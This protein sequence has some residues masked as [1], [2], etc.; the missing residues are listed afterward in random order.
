MGGNLRTVVGVDEA[1]YGPL[2]GPLVVG[3]A[4]FRLTGEGGGTERRLAGVAGPRGALPVGDSKRIYRG[5]LGFSALERSVLAFARCAARC[6]VPDAPR[7]TP[8]WSPGFPPALPVEAGGEAVRAGQERLAEALRESGV[9]VRAVMTRTVGVAEFNHGVE[10]LGSKAALLFEAAMEV[11]A[12]WIEEDGEVEVR[13]D[14]HGGRRRY[15]PLLAARFP[16]TPFWVLG[17]SPGVSAYRLVRPG[18]EITVSFETR[19]D[20]RYFEVGLASMAAKYVRE[21]H[22]RAFNAYFSGADPS[23]R[24]TAGYVGD[25]R[26]WLRRS[27]PVRR[28]LAVPDRALVRCR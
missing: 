3:L 28:R 4:A 20:G 8:P 10:R 26:R 18:G 11:A 19:A 9:E 13:F 21:L 25:A 17:E 24:P 12:P 1:G 7:E 16:G 15:G 5:G 22:M 14:R 2:L 23:L 6:E 27:A